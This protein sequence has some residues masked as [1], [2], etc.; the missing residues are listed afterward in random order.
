MS[1][2]LFSF[3]EALAVHGD[4]IARNS[5]AADEPLKDDY[6]DDLAMRRDETYELD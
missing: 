2:E 1:C 5:E 3:A 4:G 6:N